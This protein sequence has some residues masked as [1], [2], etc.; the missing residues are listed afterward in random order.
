MPPR[1]RSLLSIVAGYVTL[2]VLVNVSTILSATA[3]GIEMPAEVGGALQRPSAPYSLVNLL[4]SLGA[5][6]V[7]GYVTA[8]IAGGHGVRHAAILGGL[9][10]L[11]GGGYQLGQLVRGALDGV[12]VEPAWYLL[13]L[14]TLSLPVI[15]AGGALR[16][17]QKAA[18]AW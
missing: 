13:L 2:A 9:V 1:L 5:A 8:W 14:P 6:A 4:L 16:A 17:R 7:A 12:V 10:F 11:L 3:L 18:Q 15:I